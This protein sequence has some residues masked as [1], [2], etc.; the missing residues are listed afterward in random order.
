MPQKKLR[1]FVILLLVVSLTGFG[2]VLAQDDEQVTFMSTQFNIVEESEAFR[3][4]LEGYDSAVE[5]IPAEEADM[6]NLMRAEAESGEGTVD[7][8]GAL[9]GTF[10]PLANDDLLFDL[11]DLLN[12]IEE[13]YDLADSFVELGKLGTDDYQYYIPWL[14]ATY[15]MA[16]HVDALEYLPEGV[17]LNSMTWDE[18]AQWA[19]A[20]NEGTGE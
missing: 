15:V 17:D 1:S 10:P 9:H 6:I 3:G 7:L 14:Q 13:E 8:L 19:Q 20:L 5:F 16:A 18:F 11:T 12:S 4:V 2:S